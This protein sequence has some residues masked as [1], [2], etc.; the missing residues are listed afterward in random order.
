MKDLL[1]IISD[2]PNYFQKDVIFSTNIST[3]DYD[4]YGWV[5]EQGSIEID[6]DADEK[7][8]NLFI[9]RVI[10][11]IG[12]LNES[13]SRL[14]DRC[15]SNGIKLPQFR[16]N[17]LFYI[18]ISVGSEKIT[19]IDK[20]G[21]GLFFYKVNEMHQAFSSVKHY[22][23]QKILKYEILN[24]LDRELL[25]EVISKER[26]HSNANDLLLIYSNILKQKNRKKIK[27]ANKR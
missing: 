8:K 5:K 6:I 14:Y 10:Q 19:V 21:F 27:K 17:S 18:K 24:S 7:N 12:M 2:N 23:Q 3:K 26:N 13:I 22:F 16:L 1:K 20:S 9:I 15:F 25:L 4:E 11:V